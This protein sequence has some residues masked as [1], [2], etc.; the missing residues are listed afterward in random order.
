MKNKKVLV[1]TAL[2]LILGFTSCSRLAPG[3]LSPTQTAVPQPTAAPVPTAAPAP[4]APAAPTGRKVGAGI[5]LLN[6]PT[7]L[8]LEQGGGL[9]CALGEG[10]IT[11]PSGKTIVIDGSPKRDNI[12][13]IQGSNE[14]EGGDTNQVLTIKE[15]PE[16]WASC[17]LIENRKDNSTIFADVQPQIDE[18]VKNS[19][20]H[21]CGSKCD[22]VVV[23]MVSSNG[24]HA[25]TTKK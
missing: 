18:A 12:I 10:K 6:D 21:N 14:V 16:P 11:L 23:W 24:T 22:E 5:S 1:Y 7:K 2:V 13:V 19:L 17:S 8:P 4:V 15:F 3:S 20:A 9:F 25:K